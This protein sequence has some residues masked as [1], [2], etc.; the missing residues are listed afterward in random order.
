MSTATPS[1]SIL[2]IAPHTDLRDSL[3]FLLGAEGFAVETRTT[4]LPGD[5]V[6]AN[7]ALVMDHASLVKGF[8]DNGVLKDL[9]ARLIV[10]AS[11]LGPPAGLKDATLVRKPLHDHTLIDAL[12][13]A[14]ERYGEKGE[15]ISP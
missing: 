4:W 8:R 11:Q 6:G 10:L 2:V 5:T 15:R 7:Q 1:T 13:S 3:A 12:K 9:G 14:L